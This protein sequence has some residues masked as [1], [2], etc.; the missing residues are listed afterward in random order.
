MMKFVQVAVDNVAASKNGS[1]LF[2][3]WR[4]AQALLPL[5]TGAQWY[6]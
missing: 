2:D 1:E 3:R 5:I 6:S 4:G